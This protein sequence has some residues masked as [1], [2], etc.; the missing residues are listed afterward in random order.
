M[1]VACTVLTQRQISYW[2]NET[3]AFGHAAEVTTDNEVAYE[4]TSYRLFQAGKRD[5]AIQLL[6]QA[7]KNLPDSAALHNNLGMFYKEQK[8]YTEGEAQLREALRLQPVYPE[9]Q[10]G[11]AY[12]CL[13]DGRRSEA[14]SLLKQALQSRPD[15]RVAEDMLRQATNNAPQ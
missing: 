14:I 1:L 6:E 8:R 4:H 11:L 10:V 2:K 5:E 13:K 9:A 12:I 3:T 15:L 7:V